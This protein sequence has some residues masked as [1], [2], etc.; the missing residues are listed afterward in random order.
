MSYT[1][2]V[3]CGNIMPQDLLHVLASQSSTDNDASILRFQ[4]SFATE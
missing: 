3:E 1:Y 4:E 2:T